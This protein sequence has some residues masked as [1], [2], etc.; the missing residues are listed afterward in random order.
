MQ[1]SALANSNRDIPGLK[2]NWNI[3]KY[4]KRKELE[5]HVGYLKYIL[6]CEYD[7]KF[8]QLVDAREAAGD[9]NSSSQ[10]DMNDVTGTWKNQ[11]GRLPS[12]LVC[13]DSFKQPMNE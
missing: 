5:N 13:T 4:N 7:C 9:R 11:Q 1:K 12:L 6:F 3:R 10:V 8:A 2:G